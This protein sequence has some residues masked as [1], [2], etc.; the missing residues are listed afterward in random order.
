MNN[1]QSYLSRLGI[2][3]AISITAEADTTAASPT[4]NVDVNCTFDQ[5]MEFSFEADVSSKSN[6][7]IGPGFSLGI[8]NRNIFGGGEQFHVGITGSYEWQ[9]GRNSGSNFNSYEAGI[10][11][12]LAIPRLIAPWFV[13][14]N[15]KA[16]NWTRFGL[17]AESLARPHY[18]RLAQFSASM[19][20]EWQRRKYFSYTFTPLKLSYMKLIKTTEVF[21]SIMAANRA[22]QLS[23]QNQLIPQMEWTM[24]YDRTMNRDNLLNLQLS[25]TE[26]G[27]ICWALWSLT[28]AK[29]D[30]EVFGM[31][32][33]QFVRAQAQLVYSHRLGGSH[34]LVSRVL[35]GAAH[36]YGNSAEVPYNEQFYI[37]G[38]NSIRA[39]AVR[40]IG[41]GSYH[42]ATAGANSY[43]DETGTFKL[44]MNA[45]YRFP[46]FGPV[47]GAVFLDAG[48]V[49]L[50]KNDPLRPGGQLRASS[51]L[52]DIALGTGAGVRVDLG[53]IVLRGDLG[54][55][56]HDPYDTGV[57]GYYNIPKFSKGLA[58]HLA[59]GYPF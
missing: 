54:V 31:R 6:S 44:E 59:I 43:F 36:A 40:S 15:R 38:A 1:T 19:S 7:Y 45:E 10:N 29:R 30:K 5:P 37:G 18:F 34:W 11:T 48:N 2:F 22:V 9:T 58:F 12:S 3:S 47:N 55:A 20:Y 27:N 51:F 23:F 53:M 8:T 24:T 13:R 33:S 42:P 25:A 50:L 35:I 49:W 56:L 4:L 28:G 41:P 21:D 14:R 39:F 46:I 16:L 32:F 52:D 26:A 57:S 17:S